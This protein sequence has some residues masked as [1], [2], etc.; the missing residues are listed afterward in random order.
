[1]RSQ[2]NVVRTALKKAP[3]LVQPI[4]KHHPI[5]MVHLSRQTLG[6]HGL[7]CEVL[8]LFD[9]MVRVYFGRL[10]AS[11]TEADVLRHLHTLKGAAAG[12]GAWGIAELAKAAEA[13]IREG[14][15]VNPE[16]IDDLDI[17]VQEVSAFIGEIL[18]NEPD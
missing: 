12:V 5:D 1:M 2:G 6:D 8:R 9:Q 4:H 18:A 7:E 11:T 17:A 15:T 10:E 3:D 13:D 14:G 16:R